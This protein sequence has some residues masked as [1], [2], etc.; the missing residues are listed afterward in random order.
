MLKPKLPV[1]TKEYV[2]K[3]PNTPTTRRIKTPPLKT[4]SN[5]SIFKAPVKPYFNS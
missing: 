2:I 5:S 1:K 4:T 3:Q